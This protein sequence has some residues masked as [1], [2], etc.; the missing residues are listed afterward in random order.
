MTS[1]TLL[2]GNLNFCD[3]QSKSYAGR[4]TLKRSRPTEHWSQTI[5][6]RKIIDKNA[7]K[8]MKVCGQ[9]IK[10]GLTFQP[11]CVVTRTVASVSLLLLQ[12]F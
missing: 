8:N 12:T 11:E 1:T 5:M 2:L 9:L 4:A 10:K 3:R 7:K 6:K